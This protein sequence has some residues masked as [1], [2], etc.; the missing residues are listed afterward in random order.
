[1]RKQTVSLQFLGVIIFNARKRSCGKVM[2]SQVSVFPQGGGGLPDRDPPLTVTQP[3]QRPLS[4]QRYPLDTDPPVQKQAGGTHPTGMHSCFSSVLLL[5][6]PFTLL[7]CECEITNCQ[8]SNAFH[9]TSLTMLMEFKKKSFA[10][11][12]VIV[13]CEQALTL[14]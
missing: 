3:E 7:E 12:S 8:V 14:A 13:L 9:V 4:G 5:S 2:F 6:G 10:F 11:A 1:M